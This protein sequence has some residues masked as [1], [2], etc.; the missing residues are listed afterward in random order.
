MPGLWWLLIAA[1]LLLVLAVAALFWQ[2]RRGGGSGPAQTPRE[3]EEFLREASRLSREFDRLLGE[4]RELV[5]AS[6]DGIDQRLNELRRLAVALDQRL[7]ETR[8]QLATAT[9]AVAAPAPSGTTPAVPQEEGP[10]PPP[11]DFRR[12]VLDLARQ[13]KKAPEIAAAIGRPRGEVEL[14]LG[15]LGQGQRG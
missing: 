7:A 1:D 10:A 14:V 6:L 12:Q 11:T 4:K 15:L 9:T 13:G 8:S 2:I 3:M 5:A